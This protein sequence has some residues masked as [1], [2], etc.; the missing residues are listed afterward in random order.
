[1]G[2]AGCK[3]SE[4]GSLFLRFGTDK[5]LPHSLSPTRTRDDPK[6]RTSIPLRDAELPST[7]HLKAP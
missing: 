5:G 1:M 3:A 4:L 7:P 6:M 2:D